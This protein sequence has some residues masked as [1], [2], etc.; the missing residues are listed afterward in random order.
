M[1]NHRTPKVYVYFITASSYCFCF[2]QEV[3]NPHLGKFQNFA[4][5]SYVFHPQERVK[6]L[7]KGTGPRLS[8]QPLSHATFLMLLLVLRPQPLRSVLMT[9]AS[10]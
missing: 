10:G 4:L 1:L 2:A 8:A 7:L 6:H 5:N 3:P 9:S